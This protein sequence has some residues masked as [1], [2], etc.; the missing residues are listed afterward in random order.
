[1]TKHMEESKA[2]AEHNY[3]LGTAFLT[4]IQSFQNT[5]YFARNTEYFKFNV[6][7]T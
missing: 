1:M 6:R 7:K 4:E 3:L 2:V 5:R